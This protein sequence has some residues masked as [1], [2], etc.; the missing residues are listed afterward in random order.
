MPK[1]RADGTT[2]MWFVSWIY[3]QNGNLESLKIVS[4]VKALVVR[5][6]NGTIAW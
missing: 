3:M 5:G 4:C 6:T 2:V 1:R